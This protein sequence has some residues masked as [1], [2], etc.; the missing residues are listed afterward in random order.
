MDPLDPLDFSAVPDIS[1]EGL[2]ARLQK[3][4]D[5]WEEHLSD[6]DWDKDSDD[7]EAKEEAGERRKRRGKRRKRAKKDFEQTTLGRHLA[8]N[9]Y[10]ENPREFE[11]RCHVM[12]HVLG[13]V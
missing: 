13:R 2:L 9:F 11:D 10:E 7:D 6:E 12:H 1:A 5:E 8:A 3:D 4:L